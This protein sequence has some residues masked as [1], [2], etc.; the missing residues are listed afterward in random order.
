MKVI[1]AEGL[2]VISIDQI[3]GISLCLKEPS[4]TEEVAAWLPS[5]LDHYFALVKPFHYLPCC[6][7][8]RNRRSVV[9]ALGAARNAVEGIDLMHRM[10][11]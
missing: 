3:M 5:M 11:L 4:T 6:Y 10:S 7:S 2:H 1:A 8:I 9:R